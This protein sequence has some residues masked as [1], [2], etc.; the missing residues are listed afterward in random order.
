MPMNKKDLLRVRPV[1]VAISAQRDRESV[2]SRHFRRAFL[3]K[4]GKRYALE[5]TSTPVLWTGF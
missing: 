1:L 4:F 2:V 5:Q 3:R